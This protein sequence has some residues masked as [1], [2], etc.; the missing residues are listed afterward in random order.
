MGGDKPRPYGNEFLI[1]G[2][3]TKA[4]LRRHGNRDAFHR[5]LMLRYSRRC[6]PAKGMTMEARHAQRY[7]RRRSLSPQSYEVPAPAPA[8][9]HARRPGAQPARPVSPRPTDLLFDTGG[10]A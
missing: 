10:P 8:G 4:G 1:L 5:Q 6:T 3:E 9:R 7:F 2:G